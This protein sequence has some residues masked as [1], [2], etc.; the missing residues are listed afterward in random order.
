MELNNEKL[1]Q[2]IAIA[3]NN[4]MIA[5]EI[6]RKEDAASKGKGS[7]AMATRKLSDAQKTE[8]NTAIENKVKAAFKKLG[9]GEV[10]PRVDVMTFNRWLEAG[11]KVKTGEKSIKVKQFRLF[12]KKQVVALTAQEKADIAANAN[13]ASAAA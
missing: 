4:A 11:Y 2:L 12:H 7:K 13:K 5:A 3:V 10:T 8:R 9:Y 6:K 1:A